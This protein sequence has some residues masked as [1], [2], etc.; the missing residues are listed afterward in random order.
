M[1]WNNI[2]DKYAMPT[3]YALKGYKYQGLIDIVI[4]VYNDRQ[5]LQRTL[6]SLNTFNN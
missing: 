5:G 4:P 3:D 2:F 1:D 6:F